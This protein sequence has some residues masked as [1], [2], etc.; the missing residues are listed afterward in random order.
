MGAG[1]SSHQPKCILPVL[2]MRLDREVSD[3]LQ[4]FHENGRLVRPAP[5]SS[6]R[7]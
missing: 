6:L 1:P 4:T 7:R 2:H 3:L 5:P